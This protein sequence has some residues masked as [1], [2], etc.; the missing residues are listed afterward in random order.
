MLPKIICWIVGHKL[1]DKTNVKDRKDGRV[2]FNRIF[3]DVCP[4]CGKK[5][6][7]IKL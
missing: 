6:K 3:L 5:L 2:E 7:K 4:R 1:W